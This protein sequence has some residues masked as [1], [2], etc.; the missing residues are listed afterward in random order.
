MTVKQM[1]RRSCAAAVA[2]HLGL[3]AASAQAP[4]TYRVSVPEPEHHWLQVEAVFPAGDRGPLVITMSR[5]S[6]GRY[7]TH[8][9]SKNIFEFTAFDGAG[10]ELPF[11]R[12][13][14]NQWRIAQHDGAVRIVYKIYGDRI[15]G[16]YLGVDPTHAHMNMPATLAWAEGL[17]GINIGPRNH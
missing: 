11:A 8:E 3:L 4:V 7:A 1:V 12:P 2:L 10:R 15:D 14:V 5:S 9:F 17:D 13:A 16:T 6:P